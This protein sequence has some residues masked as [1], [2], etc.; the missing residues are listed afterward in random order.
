MDPADPIHRTLRIDCGP[1]CRLGQE[2]TGALQ[3]TPRVVTVVG[4][5]G[6]T[7]HGQRM[8]R[9]QQQR[10][11]SADEHRGVGVHPANRTVF[12]EPS[13]PWGVMDAHPLRRT[14]GTGDHFEQAAA[15][16][17]PYRSQR[18]LRR[19]PIH[20]TQRLKSGIVV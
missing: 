10:T 1:E 7:G 19:H 8:Q 15:Q 14:V 20:P 9:L 3:S 11:Q 4:V 12:G 18:A 13:R 2:G 6:D 5:L 16:C 17:V